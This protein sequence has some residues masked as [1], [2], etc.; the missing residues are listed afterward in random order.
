MS[1]LYMWLGV[2]DAECCLQTALAGGLLQ[3]FG[4]KPRTIGLVGMI[5][6]AIN[7]YT[8][9]PPVAHVSKAPAK[10]IPGNSHKQPEIV[11]EPK[12]ELKKA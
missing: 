7:C 5:A 8:L 10:A 12:M 4:W 11:P 3:L 6:S 1:L 9:F 2:T